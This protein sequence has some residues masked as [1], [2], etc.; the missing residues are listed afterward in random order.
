LK[1]K[2]KNS[3]D[4]EQ[5][6]DCRHDSD[7]SKAFHLYVWALFLRESITFYDN[8][9]S[10]PISFS[11]LGAISRQNYPDPGQS[12][13]KADHTG[14]RLLRRVSEEIRLGHCLEILHRNIRLPQSVRNYWWQG[15][16]GC[17]ESRYLYYCEIIN[18]RWTFFVFFVGSAIHK[19]KIPL[20]Y[21]FTLVILHIIWNP[22]IQAS[23]KNV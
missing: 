21:L 14:V 18:I 12:R 22:W 16:Y 10:E 5:N 19:F 23:I 20:K 2:K 9:S 8:K 6:R 4:K 11:I 7:S 17:I 15:T 1:L 13:V 3:S